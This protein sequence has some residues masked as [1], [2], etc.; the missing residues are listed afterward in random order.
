MVVWQNEPES[1]L[2]D[3]DFEWYQWNAE[4]SKFSTMS[5]VQNTLCAVYVDIGHG[6]ACTIQTEVACVGAIML[7]WQGFSTHALLGRSE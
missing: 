7:Q 1:F 5:D 2:V 3:Y 4:V 6:S